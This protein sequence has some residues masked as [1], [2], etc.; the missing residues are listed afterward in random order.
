[1]AGWLVRGRTNGESTRWRHQMTACL[2]RMTQS[3]VAIGSQESYQ[4]NAAS[5]ET[6]RE[7]A[8]Q[9]SFT[10]WVTLAVFWIRENVANP[11]DWPTMLTNPP[12]CQTTQLEKVIGPAQKRKGVKSPIDANFGVRSP[13]I[14]RHNLACSDRFR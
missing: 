13:S 2:L 4:S 10:K 6:S 12:D 11:E 3:F 1:M 7:A 14:A 8:G 9:L 5:Q